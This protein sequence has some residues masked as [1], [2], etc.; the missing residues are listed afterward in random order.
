MRELIRHILKE[1]NLKQELK[2]VIE[3]DNIFKAADLVGGMDNL[4]SI[5]KDEPEMSSLF[6]K[7]TGTITFYY[8]VV[9]YGDIKFPLDYEIIGSR[10]FPRTM[11]FK[12]LLKENTKT[13]YK[14]DLIEFDVKIPPNYFSQSILKR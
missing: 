13:T 9:A 2:K 6:D 3:D 14:F 5:F 10:N 11:I 1:N 7:L 4:K 8:P 12:D